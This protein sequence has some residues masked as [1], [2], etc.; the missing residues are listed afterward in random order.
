MSYVCTLPGFNEIK[1]RKF[2]SKKNTQTI[3]CKT[4]WANNFKIPKGHQMGLN[5][6][7]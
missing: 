5:L 2:Y 1:N 4:A 6:V 7:F 3:C